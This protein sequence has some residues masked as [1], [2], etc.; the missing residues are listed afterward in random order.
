MITQE[1]VDELEACTQELR[2][3][4]DGLRLATSLVASDPSP[5]ADLKYTNLLLAAVQAGKDYDESF[6][7][8]TD[9]AQQ[10]GHQEEKGQ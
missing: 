4:H 7:L 5:A 9:T 2:K 1:N 3:V 8:Y 10:Y 6:N